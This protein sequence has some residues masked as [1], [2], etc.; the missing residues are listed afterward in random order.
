[1]S[2]SRLDENLLKICKEITQELRE[3]PGAN[4]FN[5][6]VN[7]D[8][9]TNYYKKIKNPQD[10]GT[11]Y[12]KLERGEYTE[13]KSWEKDINTVWQNAEL[14]NGKDSYVSIIAHHMSNHFKKL[15]QRLDMKKISGWMKYLYLS[16]EKLDRLLLS[17]PSSVGT[18]FPIRKPSDYHNYAPF[19]SRELDCFIEASRAF[20][21]KDD[22]LQI[23]KI[24]QSEKQFDK[25]TDE[26]RINVEDITPR[27]LHMLRDFFKKRLHQMNQEYP[28]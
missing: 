11:I 23:C 6:P 9:Q 19:S 24:L 2:N 16:R 21:N 28:T 27:S 3:Y 20:Y 12:E 26:V 10:L 15:K 8:H 13:V 17:P 25:Q 22:L 7:T 4:L 5:E 18:I 14:Y 1:M